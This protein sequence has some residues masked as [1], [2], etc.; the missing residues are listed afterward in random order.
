MKVFKR[1]DQIG[2]YEIIDL[3][4]AGQG[5]MAA[6]YL[7]RPREKYRQQSPPIVAVKVAYGTHNDF[8]KYEIE[9]ME[10]FSH[11]HLLRLLP[12]PRS[13]T[14]QGRAVY[15]AKVETKG[16]DAAYYIAVEYMR[17]GSLEGVL[18]QRGRLTPTEAVEIGIQ[19]ADALAHMHSRQVVHLD[20]KASNILLRDPV[21]RIGSRVPKAVVSDFGI[22]WSTERK[23]LPTVYG[24][25]FY[26]AP[27]RA[28]GA[29]PHPRN[30]VFSTGVLIYELLCGRPPFTSVVVAGTRLQE[31]S[32]PRVVN[33]SISSELEQVILRAI[34]TE[35]AERYQSAEELSAALKSLPGLKL[36]GRIRRPLLAGAREYTLAS[37]SA[38]LLVLL[39]GLGALFFTPGGSG[40]PVAAPTAAA[41]NE[42]AIE[43]AFVNPPP[44]VA[45]APPTAVPTDEPAPAGTDSR[46]TSTSIPPT[47]TPTAAPTRVPPTATPVPPTEVP[48]P[49]T[50]VPAEPPAPTADPAGQPPTSDATATP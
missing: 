20:I 11:P 2:P 5:G 3:L 4:P 16:E 31:H 37:L 44:T 40:A 38:V 19:V 27:E 14:S 29:A 17:G 36:P 39:L 30:D 34:A 43:D 47:A 23:Q 12:I 9:H 7:A 45:V 50:E 8:L 6:V 25:Q 13:G 49:P 48:P 46:P 21:P 1:G 18:K 26:T 32:L 35:P 15:T 10:R 41:T 22:A 33:P 42:V 24:S 28:E